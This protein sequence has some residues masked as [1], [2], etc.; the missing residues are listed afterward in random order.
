M[1]NK[2]L[3]E[4][5]WMFVMMH[6]VLRIMLVILVMMLLEELEVSVKLFRSVL[7]LQNDEILM[8]HSTLHVPNQA[9]PMNTFHQYP[10]Q[11]LNQKEDLF[12]D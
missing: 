7:N 12:F 4:L 9:I 1:A 3:S 10:N 8:Q 6:I 5:N 2:V 11:R